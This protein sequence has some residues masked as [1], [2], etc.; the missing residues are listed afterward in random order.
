MIGHEFSAR[1]AGLEPPAASY[2]GFQGSGTTSAHPTSWATIRPLSIAGWIGSGRTSGIIALIGALIAF[3]LLLAAIVPI[4]KDE[5]YYWVLSKH[6]AA[7]YYD[8]PPMIAFVIRLGT[9][10]AGDTL[11]GVRIV[12]ILAAVPCTWLIWRTAAILFGSDRLGARAALYFNLT[13]LSALVITFPDAP[14]ALATVFMMFSIAKAMQTGRGEW[15]VGAGVAAGFGLLSK[16]TMLLT[17]AAVLLWLLTDGRARSWLRTP[18]PYLGGAVAAFLFLPTILWNAQHGYASFL[19]QFDRVRPEEFNPNKVL[20]LMGHQIGLVTPAILVLAIA[21]ILALTRHRG[22]VASGGL[23]I[24]VACVPFGYFLWHSIHE[25]V[26]DH[27]LF[28]F[29]PALAMLAA[30]G[31]EPNGSTGAFTRIAAFCR[32]HAVWMALATI[33][34]ASLQ[35]TAGFPLSGTWD[36]IARQVAVGWTELAGQIEAVRAR[37]GAPAVLAGSYELTSTLRFYLPASTAVVS[38]AEPIRWAND[39][40]TK[41]D[42]GGGPLLLVTRHGKAA[43]MVSGYASFVPVATL[44]RASHG[45]PIEEIELYL[46]SGETSGAPAKALIRR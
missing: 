3:R 40:T 44:A 16:Y 43:D 19:M 1:L 30:V 46:I 2:T 28:S 25:R 14:L 33:G 37:V 34:I 38:A 24:A 31:A 9:L 21:G 23:L 45:V 4:Y 17:G 26:G 29:Y 20:D 22:K 11:L 15:W 36:P 42:L 27:W 18:W 8:H 10:I 32:R 41:T 39:P 7:G 13:L 35:A 5:A 6:L 12:A